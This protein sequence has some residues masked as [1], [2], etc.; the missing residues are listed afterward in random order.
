[1]I[2]WI[3]LS[4]AFFRLASA[5]SRAEKQARFHL[6]SEFISVWPCQYGVLARKVF[7]KQVLEYCGEN[8]IIR[9]GTIFVHPETEFGDNVFIG[10]HCVIGLARV[11]SHVMLA[12]HVSILSGRHHHSKADD[13]KE[14]PVRLRK[15]RL[16]RVRIGDN[17]WIGASATVMADVG[18]NAIVGAG[19]VVV[20][21]VPVGATAAGNP[22]RIIKT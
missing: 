8:P 9:F 12:H 19:A 6:I 18:E 13:A 22:A 17:V 7:Y 20:H 10:N 15:G 14:I 11:G 4:P 1:M 2:T 5:R 3:I 21:P 16:T